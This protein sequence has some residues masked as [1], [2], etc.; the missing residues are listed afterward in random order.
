[1]LYWIF[2][3]DGTLYQINSKYNVVD[4][5]YV[6]YSF[7]KEDKKI[8]ALLNMLK[9][10]K[11]IMTNSVNQHC[12]NIINKLKITDCF[13]HTFDRNTFN[14]LMKPHPKTYIKLISDLKMKKNDFCVFF[15]DSPINLIMAKKFGWMTV[16]ITPFPWKY[17]NSHQGIDLVFPTV[18]SAVAFLIKKIYKL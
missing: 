6:N 18:H 16:L 10:K 1:M 15:D 13:H 3:L 11:V 14:G 17:Q 4:D 8:K 7:I 12:Q 5:L 2:D 9:G